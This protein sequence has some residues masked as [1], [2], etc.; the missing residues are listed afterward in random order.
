MGAWLDTVFYRFDYAILHAIHAFAEATEGAWTPLMRAISFLGDGGICMCILAVILFLFRKHRKT[1]LFMLLSLAIASV[2]FI[3][4][5]KNVA[6]R[7]RPYADPTREF[8]LWWQ[9][10][11]AVRQKDLSFPSG[12]TTATT[13]AMLALFLTT[14]KRR[15]FPA[16][17]FALLMGLSRMYLMV[18]YPT[19]VIGGLIA[20]AI[21]AGLAYPLVRWIL[22]AVHAHPQNAFCA[23]FLHFDPFVAL[24]RRF[25][26]RRGGK[27]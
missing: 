18:H 21:G 10:V 7:A 5:F 13:A 19:D 2:L 1:G 12:H 6:A 22:R 23:W 8:F 9:S 16:L 17:L 3:W 20:G 14:D 26:G 15:S 25:V 4:I 11:G 24:Y 27:A